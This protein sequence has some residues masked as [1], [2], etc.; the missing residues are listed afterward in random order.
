LFRLSKT[1]IP[2][3][4]RAI[5]RT[6]SIFPLKGGLLVA[7]LFLE[8]YSYWRPITSHE[9]LYRRDLQTQSFLVFKMKQNYTK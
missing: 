3:Y 4:R 8:V 9:A 2:T 6:M 5:G 7:H 1:E